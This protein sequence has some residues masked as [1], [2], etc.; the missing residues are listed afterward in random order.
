MNENSP[1]STIATT[2][3]PATPPGDQVSAGW[4]VSG[5][6]LGLLAI[7]I[8]FVRIQS[9]RYNPPRDPRRPQRVI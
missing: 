3:P 5:I 7:F 9:R 8:V 2:A 6:I 1:F 4:Y